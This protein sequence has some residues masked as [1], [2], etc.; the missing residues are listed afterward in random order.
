[1]KPKTV[2]MNILGESADW[3]YIIWFCLTQKDIITV[4]VNVL[5]ER[6]AVKNIDKATLCGGLC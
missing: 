5:Q 1:M 3:C 2:T 4:V 6:H